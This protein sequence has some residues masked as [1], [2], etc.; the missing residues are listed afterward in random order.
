M[1]PADLL[2][3]QELLGYN[4]WRRM[5]VD[6]AVMLTNEGSNGKKLFIELIMAILGT[7]NYSAR[8]IQELSHNRFA[9]ADL[10]GKMANLSPDLPNTALKETGTFKGLCSGDEMQAEKKG[11][12]PFKFS[13]YAK[14]WFSANQLPA[15]FDPTISY[16]RRW[17]I[18]TFPYT[19]H[20]YDPTKPKPVFSKDSIDRVAKDREQLRADLTTGQEFSGYLNYWLEGLARLR[21]NRWHFS[22][23]RGFEEIKEAYIRK[24]N[25][26]HAFV[27]DCLV[28]DPEAEVPKAKVYA[29]F[30]EYCRD[31]SLST[32]DQRPFFTNLIKLIHFTDTRPERVIDGKKTRVRCTKGF[33][34]KDKQFWGKQ[35]DDDN[36]NGNESS[37]PK[38]P[39]KNALDAYVQ[40]LQAEDLE[41]YRE[42]HWPTLEEY[43]ETYAAVHEISKESALEL[44]K[45]AVQAG[46]IGQ[47]KDGLFYVLLSQDLLSKR[48]RV[49][50]DSHTGDGR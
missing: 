38:E 15:V 1:Y 4:L 7:E 46:V 49:G 42:I 26:T 45:G 25:P 21:R 48:L 37:A 36:E 39:D 3:M 14:P 10:Y 40:R 6:V 29:T 32:I 35:L 34:V 11:C 24:S 17:K 5:D 18:F 47:G 28:T 2:E 19:F 43:A 20:E 44:F 9:K 30:C 8:T 50:A 33:M 16:Y 31:L 12:N 41:H 13:P 22:G 23:S 27:I